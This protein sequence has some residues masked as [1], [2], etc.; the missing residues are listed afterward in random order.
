MDFKLLGG[1]L[2]V[3]GTAIGAGM[4]A[5]PI[6][7]AHLG[8]MGSLVLLILCWIVMTGGA[9]LLLEANLWMPLNSNLNT[10]ARSTIGPVG[11]LISWFSF[12]MLLYSLLCA[13]ISGGS[14]LFHHL[15]NMAHVDISRSTASVLF[16]LL[17]GTVVYLG[18]KSVDYV[19]R[20]LMLIKFTAYFL[21]I[22]LLM[23]LV[24]SLKLAAGDVGEVTST[25]AI[26][27]TITSFGYAAIVP[28]LRIYFSGDVLKL[29]KAILIGSLIPLV[30]YIAWDAAIMGIIPLG[31]EHG[32]TAILQSQNSTSDLVKT[33]SSS[34][35]SSTIAVLAQ[36]FTSVCVLTSF[37]G[38][39]LCLTDFWADGL[40]LEKKGKN[41]LIICGATFLPPLITVL[42][43]P[44]IFVK[45]LEYAGIACV[46]LLVLLPAWMVWAG[47]YKRYFSNHFTVP[48]G[49]FPLI[50]LMIFS[51]FMIIRGCAT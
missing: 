1:V 34:A 40:G 41:H 24:S 39:S 20:G 3:V 8:F 51:V 4:L 6:A 25:T 11:Q 50:I 14:D 17:F 19:N 7:T 33:L 28:S 44:G 49:K 2:L 13:Y 32:L 12:L 26:M 42:F 35:A 48:G 23:P 22:F 16:T 29:K 37:L 21:L 38:V 5:L 36:L 30:C 10:M 47:R 43:F 27:V 9:F 31:G 15:L 45:A 18:I 46:V